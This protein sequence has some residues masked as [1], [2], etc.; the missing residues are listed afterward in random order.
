MAMAGLLL[1]ANNS[2]TWIRIASYLWTTFNI[3]QTRYIFPS[4]TG[5]PLTPN[6][7]GKA[8]KKSTNLET[9]F[10]QHD[11]NIPIN[12]K[13]WRCLTGQLILHPADLA[14]LIPTDSK[15]ETV[16]YTL[17]SHQ[18][19]VSQQDYTI[20]RYGVYDFKERRYTT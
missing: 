15:F 17:T 11:K 12:N 10:Q 5:L 20:Q 3:F 2:H 6:E 13:T 19:R 9:E 14:Y 16:E 8:P 1:K 4:L 7:L 18:G